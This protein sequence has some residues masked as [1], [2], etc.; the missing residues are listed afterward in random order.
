[1]SERK[2]RPPLK[3]HGGKHYMVRRILPL[4]PKHTHYVEPFFG[5]GAVYFAK[6]A[7][8]IHKHSEVI[9]DLHKELTCF[10]VVLR[11]KEAFAAF[12]QRIALTP[13][14]QVEWEHA[15]TPATDLV[16]RAVKFFVRYRMSRQGLGR[17]FATLSRNRT[18]KGM[19]EQVSAWLGA[20]EGLQDAHE[21]LRTTVILNEHAVTVIDSQDGPNTFFYLDP[22]YTPESRVSPNA[23]EHEMTR[24]DHR[25]LLECLSRIEGKFLLS[26]YDDNMYN[27][28][29]FENGWSCDRVEVPNAASGQQT[30]ELKTECLWRN[31]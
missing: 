9:N 28:F 5:S 15:A 16:S 25:E 18:R 12:Q 8:L 20:V 7:E 11:N 29:A 22:P 21:R 31:Y 14:S 4:F 17:S 24:Q 10:Y 13:F 19:N 27:T 6:P 26:G 2:V 1:M 30:K 3:W 23:Y